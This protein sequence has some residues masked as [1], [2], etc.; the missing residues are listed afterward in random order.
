MM[1]DT[2]CSPKSA[3]TTWQNCLEHISGSI[4]NQDD[5]HQLIAPLQMQEKDDR[6]LVYAPNQ[7]IFDRVKD[8]YL[9][10]IENTVRMQNPDYES[11]RI[12]FVMG[13]PCDTQPKTTTAPSR[14]SQPGPG[15][16][17]SSNPSPLNPNFSFQLR[18]CPSRILMKS[19]RHG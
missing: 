16:P 7:F 6:I 14:P 8:Q 13:H 11:M 1:P 12:S 4:E 15:A 19:Q 10:L 5:F 17:D 9:S 3:N 18:S 2:S